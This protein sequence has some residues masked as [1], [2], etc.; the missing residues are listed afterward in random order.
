MTKAVAD[1]AIVL[2]ADGV[3][4]IGG[5]AGDDTITV[6]R[7]ADGKYRITRG[8]TLVSSNIPVSSV[9]EIRIWGRAGNDIIAVADA[10][11]KTF[12]SGG[13]GNDALVGGFGGT[14]QVG[15]AGN[16]LLTG[17]SGNDVLV[18]GTGKDVLLGMAGD[19]ILIA[20]S[21]SAAHSLS[22]LRAL[23]DGWVASH[24]ATAL[25]AAA[26]D[27]AVTDT[28]SDIL[29]GGSGSDWFIVDKS[30]VLLDALSLFGSHDVVTYVT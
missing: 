15:G 22:S 9:K 17:G 4:R 10:T 23:S 28:A 19:D 27:N 29:A 24:A 14:V 13:L 25:E 8:L 21:V 18:A 6:L 2:G 3:L 5:T 26:I 30:D 7:G 20:G 1:G 16:D 11:V 12:L